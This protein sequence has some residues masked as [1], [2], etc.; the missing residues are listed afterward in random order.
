MP[1]QPGTRR[2]WL[3]ALLALLG[4]G[5]GH[6][7]A[8]R[9]GLAAAVFALW[10]GLQAAAV[11]ALFVGVRAFAVGLLAVLCYWLGQAAHAAGAAR[12]SPAGPRGWYAR[13]WGL[14]LLYAVST[15]V[16]SLAVSASRPRL[17][18]T[19][20]MPS[21]SMI[22]AL[23][24]GDVFV[25][26][27]GKR[28]ARGDVVIHAAPPGSSSR[29]PIVKRVVAVGGDLVEVRNGRL[30]LNGVPS[31]HE[32][33]PGPCTYWV[34]SPGGP[35]REDPCE[36]FLEQSGD[37]TYRVTCTPGRACGD[38][39]PT[40]VPDGHLFVLGDHRDHSADSRVYG[41]IPEAGVRA[42]AAFVAISLGPAGVRWDRI[43]APVE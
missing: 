8:G 29:D 4:N 19:N 23:Q 11:A 27:P 3:A 15:G 12:R 13:A 17:P 2:P 10:L 30:V 24:V 38:V 34:R 25:A 42:T 43:G 7:Y 35:W 14:V 20:Y 32:P 5:L 1:T 41:P 6:A 33:V 36:A 16:T 18:G 28:V 40:R 37:Q 39:E 21:A 22:P 31:R 9:P 26:V